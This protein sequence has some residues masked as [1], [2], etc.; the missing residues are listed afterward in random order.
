MQVR[1]ASMWRPLLLA[2]LLVGCGSAQEA[3][4]TTTEASTTTVERTTTTVKR[5]TT[6]E[7]RTTTTQA[8]TVEQER[9]ILVQSFEEIRADLIEALEANSAIQSVDNVAY[10][11]E[12]D[13]LVIAVTSDYSTEEYNEDL[14][15]E[16]TTELRT[17][18]GPDGVMRNVPFPVGLSLDVSDLSFRCPGEFMFR[19]GDHRA[20]RSDWLA[21][22]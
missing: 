15:W 6:T 17:V 4:T 3:A 20:T 19:L 13:Q 1:S 18:W 22:C 7:R 11:S 16:L 14:A 21:A 2:L 9:A 12:R 10:N 8:L 5:T